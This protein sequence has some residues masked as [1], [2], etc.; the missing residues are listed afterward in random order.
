M[1]KVSV[2]VTTRNEERN[3]ERCLTSINRQTYP[4][5]EIIVVDNASTDRTKEIART[6]TPSVYDRG[7]ERSA[8]RNFGVERAGGV[9][10]MY[11]DADMTLSPGVVEECVTT[12]RRDP[13][14]CGLYVPEVVVG[15]DSFWIKVRRF[16]RSFYDGTP[17]DA[18]RFFPK[19]VFERVGGFDTSLTGP[20]DWDFDRRVRAL[21]PVSVIRA[22]LYHH[23]GSLDLGTYLRKKRYYAGSFDGYIRKWGKGDP[24][25][26]RQLGLGYR[27]FGVFLEHGKFRRLLAH[28]LLTAGMYYLRF[29]VGLAYLGS[30]FGHRLS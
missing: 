17:I 22:P 13:A 19:A 7:P 24:E 15:D 9:C 3:I 2:V 1:D 16:E 20:E 28:P 12:L 10:A 23:E 8:Q 14:L 30:R 29:R 6:F 11:L 4:Q 26:R 25:V 27:Y 18:V 5:I 21:G